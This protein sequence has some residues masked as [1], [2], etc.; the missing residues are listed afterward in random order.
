MAM[1]VRASEETIEVDLW[2]RQYVTYVLA[3]HG[4]IVSGAATSPL[5]RAS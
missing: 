3:S 4:I 1:L 2:V 5:P